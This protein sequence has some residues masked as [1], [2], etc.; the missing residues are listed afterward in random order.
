M[1][2][3]RLRE[4]LPLKLWA[5][6]SMSPLVAANAPQASLMLPTPRLP[7][8]SDHKISGDYIPICS[9]KI[10]LMEFYC[11]HLCHTSF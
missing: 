5:A 10:F 6:V 9:T 8:A 3:G 11:H 2:Q 7:K 1:V 4:E